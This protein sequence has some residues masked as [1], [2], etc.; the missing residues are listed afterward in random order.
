MGPQPDIVRAR[1][2]ML[3][4]NMKEAAS[5]ERA[6]HGAEFWQSAVHAG[7]RVDG[8]RQGG[9]Y[10]MRLQE[11][12]MITAR[13]TF[14]FVASGERGDPATNTSAGRSLGEQAT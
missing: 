9:E 7:P 10:M 8:R 1:D 6:G 13:K 12:I 3:L 5:R 2:E 14:S 4:R 11:A